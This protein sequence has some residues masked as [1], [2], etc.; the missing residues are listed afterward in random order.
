M[1]FIAELTTLAALATLTLSR[2]ALA[3]THSEAA[4]RDT[5][6]DPH[7]GHDMSSYDMS[8]HGDHA[9]SGMFG[10][11]AMTREA[12]GTAWASPI[13]GGI[14]GPRH[15]WSVDAHVPRLRDARV[16]DQGGE[17][18]DEKTFANNM[19]M[20]MAQR[21]AG[22]GTFGL[23][24]ML[25]AE[26]ATMGNDGYPLLFQTG[27]TADGVSPLIDRQHP[28]D[29]SW[30][31]PRRTAFR[32][33]IARSSFMRDMP[34]EPALGPP[35]FMHRF[36]GMDN[37]EAPIGIIGSTRPT[38]PSACSP[39]DWCGTRQARGPRLQR[40]RA[41]RGP[42]EFRARLRLNSTFVAPVMESRRPIGRCRRAWGSLNHRALGARLR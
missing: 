11:Y 9:M 22:P 32:A 27:E 8:E 14:G 36:S 40:P 12:S 31:S 30:S 21:R 17:R 19:V 24:A 37:P 4:R 23:R 34:G 10:P 1:R 25:S 39:E 2:P 13:A 35:A 41:G 33:A 6:A 3:Q 26:P 7:A 38:S 29:F 18:G 28:H 42:L 16:H 5:V 15:E 20:G